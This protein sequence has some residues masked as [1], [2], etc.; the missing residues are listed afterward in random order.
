MTD[1]KRPVES[2]IT[3][4]FEASLKLL[5][6]IPELAFNT[7][8]QLITLSNLET[9]EYIEV[10]QA[11][12]DTTG[13]SRE[14]IIGKTSDDIQLYVDIIQNRKYL[15]LLSRMKKVSDLEVKLRMRSGDERSF[16]FSARTFFHTDEIYLITY[17]NDISALNDG[18]ARAESEKILREIFD[19]MNRY[20]IILR[21]GGA[22]EFFINDFNFKAEDV[23]QL[24]RNDIVGKE[25][26]ET[27]FGENQAFL[28]LLENIE[29]RE[30]HLKVPLSPD[31][32]D[33]SGY[34]SL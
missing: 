34:Y 26:G 11:F 22:G 1:R 7:T 33:D 2:E 4:A 32:T 15:R 6:E 19:S 24:D 27:P 20:A 28:T 14:E 5:S 17:Y 12:L 8:N 9:Q 18:Y 30:G 10:N 23:E 3:T 25:I 31:G 16:L 21:R 29:S 13:Y